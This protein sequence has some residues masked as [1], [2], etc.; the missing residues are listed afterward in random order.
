[1]VGPEVE[2][3]ELPVEA[4]ETEL[5]DGTRADGA[6][7][8]GAETDGVLTDGTETDGVFPTGVETDGTVTEGVWTDGTEIA[9]LD[10][11]LTPKTASRSVP[12]TDPD[13]TTRR[14]P[15]HVDVLST[16]PEATYA[17]LRP[18]HL[19]PRITASPSWHGSPP[20]NPQTSSFPSHC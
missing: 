17:S 18:L 2:D 15:S 19:L 3:P 10:S 7:T 16:A 6:D 4:G 8:D 12:R 9:E 14:A 11:V 5:R 13:P 1:M 20:P